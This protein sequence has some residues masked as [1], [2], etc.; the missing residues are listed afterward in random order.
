M[1]LYRLEILSKINKLKHEDFAKVLIDCNYHNFHYNLLLL[2]ADC[3]LN[4]NLM[5]LIGD[6][7][8]ENERWFLSQFKVTTERTTKWFEERVIGTPDRLLFII[9][10][11]DKYIGHVGLFRFDFEN[12]T[13]EIDNIVRGEPEIPGIM[14]NA[15]LNMMEWG[16]NNLDIQNYSLKVLSDNEK[17][18]RLYDRLGFIEISRIPLITVDGEDGL[19]WTEAPD[20][21][22]KAAEK[23]Y[24]VMKLVQKDKNGLDS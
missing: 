3:A 5:E 18:R 24:V 15:V 6:W 11:N 21:Y 10:A 20:E 23:Y 14:G 8:K 22:D 7:R 12:K 19:E 17:A 2:T 9:K 13:C 4:R 16:K 1:T